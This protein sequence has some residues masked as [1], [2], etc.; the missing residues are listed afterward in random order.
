MHRDL[1]EVVGV[2]MRVVGGGE[3]T[4]EEVVD[5]GFEADGDLDMALND[6]YIKLLEFSY[7]YRM[8]CGNSQLDHDARAGLKAALERLVVLAG[9]E[10]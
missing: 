1:K 9:E 5:L 2:L 3:V 6:A 8:R 10:P 4:P 7:D